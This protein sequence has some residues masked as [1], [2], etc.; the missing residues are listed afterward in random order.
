MEEVLFPEDWGEEAAPQDEEDVQGADVQGEEEEE[1]VEE[2]EEVLEEEAQEEE[3]VQEE[4]AHEEVEET[5]KNVDIEADPDDDDEDM[6]DDL[7]AMEAA[8]S[9]QWG[10]TE[11]SEPAKQPEQ[12]RLAGAVAPPWRQA[13][14][15]SASKGLE[16]GASNGCF[17]GKA[18]GK[19]KGAGKGLAMGKGGGKA[20]GLA[21]GQEKGAAKGVSVKRPLSPTASAEGAPWGKRPVAQNA[22]VG[23]A[24]AETSAAGAAAGAVKVK[25]KRV[26]AEKLEMLKGKGIKL[27]ASAVQALALAEPRDAQIL[28]AALAKKSGEIA[29][30]TRW[31]EV[32]L[33]RRAN[34][35]PAAA[36][37]GQQPAEAPAVKAVVAKSAV[38]K[39]PATKAPVAKS[40]VA[41]APAPQQASEQ[42]KAAAASKLPTG[43]KVIKLPGQKVSTPPQEAK[44]PITKAPVAKAPIAKAPVSKAPGAKAGGQA[45]PPGVDGVGTPPRLR[46]E[47]ELEFF[48]MAVQ[49]KLMALNKQGIWKGPHPLDE[50]AL[51]ALLSIDS[52]RSL[53]ILDEAEEQGKQLASPSRFVRDQVAE[54]KK[55]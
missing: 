4:E 36:T 27:G 1:V 48:Q 45:L 24:A 31:V 15:H 17:K 16:K 55:L 5:Q 18:K 44:A 8:A 47:Q 38:A 49:A 20:K 41:K 7:A 39:A 54:E 9:A 35:A 12:G 19:E 3:P 21:K 6:D 43:V 10:G 51:V 14:P 37:D 33:E 2:E 30:P 28:L 25:L 46:T 34:T 29:N 53:E 13:A 32:S 40:P 23:G 50:A 52:A 22:D 11:P 42:P 26:V